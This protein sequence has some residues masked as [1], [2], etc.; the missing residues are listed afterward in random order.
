MTT[1]FTCPAKRAARPAAKPAPAASPVAAMRERILA[2][3]A[4][5][6]RP[7]DCD[8][9]REHLGLDSVAWLPLLNQAL[10]SRR[11]TVTRYHPCIGKLPGGEALYAATPRK[12]YALVANGRVA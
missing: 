6:T 5:Q 1:T 2:F 3:L 12:L 8:P 9:I 11:I 4:T 10:T 7:I